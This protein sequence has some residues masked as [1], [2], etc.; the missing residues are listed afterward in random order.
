M[1][2]IGKTIGTLSSRGGFCSLV[3]PRRQPPSFPSMSPQKELDLVKIELKPQELVKFEPKPQELV[4]F[5]PLLQ[6]LVLS[7]QDHSKGK[8]WSGWTGPNGWTADMPKHSILEQIFKAWSF[9]KGEDVFK[10]WKNILDNRSNGRYHTTKSLF[11]MMAWAA[12]L[13]GHEFGDDPRAKPVE[14]DL[15]SNPPNTTLIGTG[16]SLGRAIDDTFDVPKIARCLFETANKQVRDIVKKKMDEFKL[17]R[18][19]WTI[20]WRNNLKEWDAFVDKKTDQFV[21][22]C[23]DVI[24][25]L[26]KELSAHICEAHKNSNKEMKV[27]T[28]LFYT[29]VKKMTN[30]VEQMTDEVEQKDG[31]EQ[32][33][34][35]VELKKDVV[36]QK[37]RAFRSSMKKYIEVFSK[38]FVA[39]AI[40]IIW[41]KFSTV[42]ENLKKDDGDDD[43][44]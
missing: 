13:A 18:E 24:F 4:K 23:N 21:K 9:A 26:F 1:I 42:A 43:D 29:T 22:L 3:I 38:H 25:P 7:P 35:G 36:E 37:D 15:P 17:S 10:D 44:K 41:A 31:E 11:A 32:M 12:Q 27:L 33:T 30:G 19:A 40:S 8:Q 39:L 6:G 20:Q 34:N 2:K 14:R 28:K 16:I 5:E